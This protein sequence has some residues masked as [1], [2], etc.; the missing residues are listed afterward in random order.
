MKKLFKAMAI[1]LASTSLFAF[2]ACDKTTGIKFEDVPEEEQATVYND[3][4]TKFEAATA[5]YSDPT[6]FYSSYT[7]SLT[8]VNTN[9]MTEQSNGVKETAT[10]K[11]SVAITAEKTEGDVTTPATFEYAYST[12]VKSKALLTTGSLTDMNVTMSQYI[13]GGQYYQKHDVTFPSY[14][15]QSTTQSLQQ[16]LSYSQETAIRAALP[17]IK[18]IS[19]VKDVFENDLT[20]VKAEYSDLT[21]GTGKDGSAY[22]I[23]F[24]LYCLKIT[25]TV[26]YCGYDTTNLVATLRTYGIDADDVR[27]NYNITYQIVL[28]SDGKIDYI[29]TIMK[30][31]ADTEESLAYKKA[32]SSFEYTEKTYIYDSL[33][34]DF[35]SDLA[36]Y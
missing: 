36:S 28:T 2:A 7:G 29:D 17:G 27:A 9:L 8:A 30:Q 12:T 34:I 3:F 15:A 19:L 4:Q 18:M 16:A 11:A 22:K 32:F 14:P 24:N 10:T 5:E 13:T 21:L 1:A 25:D 35:P 26:S 31:I 20:T 23:S 6:T 33:T